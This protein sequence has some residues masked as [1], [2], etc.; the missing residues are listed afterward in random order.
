MSSLSDV[1]WLDFPTNQDERGILTSIEGGQ[2][3]P[4][5]IK[6]VFFM[7]QVVAERGGHAHRDTDQVLFAVNG[8]L[9]IELSDGESKIIEKVGDPRRGLFIPRMIFT[10]MYNFSPDS[11]CMVLANTHY[12]R[13]KSIRTYEEFLQILKK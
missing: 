10:R 5:E 12:D 13:S 3:I 7:H 9:T 11:V 4:I 1:R 6:R 8:T 2:D